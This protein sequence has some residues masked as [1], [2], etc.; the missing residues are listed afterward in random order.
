MSTET[1][2]VIYQRAL[3]AM[4][5][6]S[7]VGKTA[8][9]R[10]LCANAP[11]YTLVGPTP[12]RQ[13]HLMSREIDTHPEGGPLTVR[14]VWLWDADGHSQ[15]HLIHPLYLD[16]VA[17]ALLVYDPMSDVEPQDGIA[18]WHRLISTQRLRHAPAPDPTFFLVAARLDRQGRRISDSR[19]ASLLQHRHLRIDGHFDTSAKDGRGIEGLAEA[20]G[21]AID[22]NWQPELTSNGC[23]VP[24]MDYLRQRRAAGE[25]VARIEDLYSGF[26]AG[27]GWEDSGELRSQFALALDQVESL[28]QARRLH[29]GIRVLLAPE[30]LDTYASAL[31]WSILGGHEGGAID[32]GLVREGAFDVP[33]SERLADKEAER[34]LLLAL[35]EDLLGHDIALRQGDWLV[36]PSLA[37]VERQALPDGGRAVS[38]SFEGAVHHTFATLVVRLARSAHFRLVELW[39]WKVAYAAPGGGI[40]WLVLG[41]PWVEGK[42]ELTLYFDEQVSPEDRFLFDAFVLDHLRSTSLPD[43]LSRQLLVACPSC[44]TDVA[45]LPR[46]RELGRSETTCPVC[47]QAQISLLDLSERLPEPA[48]SQV[49]DLNRAAAA[50]RADEVA[51]LYA[52]AAEPRTSA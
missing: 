51:Q 52:A 26:L 49:E 13:I 42:G 24:L 47:G 38:Y 15:M 35:V 32:E 44:G 3:V 11:A 6:A 27:A 23:L 31:L 46:L 43:L 8:L 9:A 39:A 21:A 33:R 10:A 18:A 20:V 45:N 2:T 22:W 30:M 34:A 7:G 29:D 17:L 50:R 14:E 19:L 40:C 4:A 12:V 16:R 48:S 37:R 41:Y 5:G 28:G 1:T 25:V 36:F